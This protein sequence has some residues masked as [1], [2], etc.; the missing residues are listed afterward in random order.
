MDEEIVTDLQEMIKHFNELKN[1]VPIYEKWIK[2]LEKLLTYET[3]REG[4]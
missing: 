4:I 1:K 2:T 3:R